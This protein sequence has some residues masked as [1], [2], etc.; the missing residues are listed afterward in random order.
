MKKIIIL[1][2][3]LLFIQPAIAGSWKYYADAQGNQLPAVG[4]N[5]S[6][7][8]GAIE[9][10][11]VPTTGL[12]KADLINKV[13]IPYDPPV[14]EKRKAAYD[15]ELGSVGDQF[16]AIYKGMII[17]VPAMAKAGFLTPEEIEALTPNKDAPKGTPALWLGKI[18]DIKE[19][20]PKKVEEQQETVK[21]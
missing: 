10:P 4:P 6:P 7:P 9:I 5:T 20:I 2:A 17:V 21:K 8:Q 11:S 14:E 1:L 19:R 13:W 16:D 18:K 15:A 12:D 3:C